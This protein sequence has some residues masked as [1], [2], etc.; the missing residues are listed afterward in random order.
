MAFTRHIPYAFP[1]RDP[2]FSVSVT[3]TS[4]LFSCSFQQDGPPSSM[5]PLVHQGFPATLAILLSCDPFF[6][7]FSTSHVI[8]SNASHFLHL[9]LLRPPVVRH[10][11][12]SMP[13]H[14]ACPRASFSAAAPA[15]ACSRMPVLAA[16]SPTR[17]SSSGTPTPTLPAVLSEL[18]TLGRACVCCAPV[19]A[20]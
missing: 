20:C 8:A 9:F 5:F 7:F 2:L 19:C 17:T 15:A 14:D 6:L 11:K 18:T 13:S 12:Q 16:L 4:H 10:S 1:C 3:I